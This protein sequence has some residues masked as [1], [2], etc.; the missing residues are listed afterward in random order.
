MINKILSVLMLAVIGFII[1]G[2]YLILYTIT[3]P[4]Q[5]TMASILSFLITI[6][7]LI[8]SDVIVFAI[9]LGTADG[10]WES[11]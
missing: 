11:D 9:L 8:F 3:V 6:T 7:L 4:F 10:L 1:Y 5:M 2:E